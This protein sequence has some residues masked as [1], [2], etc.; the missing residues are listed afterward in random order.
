LLEDHRLGFPGVTK[1][2]DHG[3][4]PE[5]NNGISIRIEP[6]DHAL[7]HSGLTNELALGPVDIYLCIDQVNEHPEV[8]GEIIIVLTKNTREFFGPAILKC[9][10]YRTCFSQ[11]QW[12]ILSL[13][14]AGLKEGAICALTNNTWLDRTDGTALNVVS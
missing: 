1:R 11:G 13:E 2:E 6:F 8:Y 10:L 5:I 14:E 4:H 3:I 9:L 7:S 12:N